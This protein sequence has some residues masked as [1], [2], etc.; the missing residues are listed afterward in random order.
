M[1]KQ[2]AVRLPDELV[3]FI[4]RQVGDGKASSRADVITHA[5]EHERRRELAI[6]DAAIFAQS[7]EGDDFEALAA[8]A[9]RIP[10]SDLD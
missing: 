9:A 2:I 7:R 8:Y 4:D 5:V 1:S 10:R 3:D 6:R